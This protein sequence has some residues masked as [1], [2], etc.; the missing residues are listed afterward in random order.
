MYLHVAPVHHAHM[1]KKQVISRLK[2]PPYRRTFIREWRKKADLTLEQVGENVGMSHAQL[3]RIE[4]GLQPYNQELLEALAV[5]FKTEPASLLMRN[6]DQTDGIWSL[7]DQAK[8]AQ[9]V[10]IEKYAE[11]VV[12]TKTGT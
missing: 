3:G 6:P 12:K 10:D 7:W 8:E 1:T 5:L 11:F 2:A 4:R 9:R